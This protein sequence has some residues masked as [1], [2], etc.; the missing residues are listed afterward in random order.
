MVFVIVNTK[1][2]TKVML[3][4]AENRDEVLERLN[5]KET[6]FIAASFTDMDIAVLN[7]SLFTVISS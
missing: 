3:V 1:I 4:K 7:S 6:E 5:L 2:R